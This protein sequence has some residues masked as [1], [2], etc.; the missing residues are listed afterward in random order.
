MARLQWRRYWLVVALALGLVTVAIAHLGV[1]RFTAQPPNYSRIEDGLWL[2]G[3]V[4]EPP[5]GTQAVLNLCESE[6]R[7]R[8]ESHKW[9]PIRDA[10]PVPSLDWLR[11]QNG[12]ISSE[13]AAGHKVFVHCRNGV[14][15]S[16][17]VMAAYLMQREGWTRDQALEFLRSRRPGVR[18]NP[19][20]M[21]LLLEW[22]RTLNK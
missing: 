22:E 17:M 11:A 1:H 2:G 8:V 19:A 6:D 12:F 10:E 21:Q 9:E 13:R 14:S 15:R 5:P 16:G 3:D 20:F 18:P 4:T 7:Y